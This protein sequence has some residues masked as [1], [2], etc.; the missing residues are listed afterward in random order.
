MKILLTAFEPFGGEDTNSSLDTLRALPEA[1]DVCRA[2]LPVTFSGSVPALQAA[3]RRVRPDA[4]LCLGQ[5]GGA[6]CIRVERV[7]LNLDDARMADNAGDIPRD[8]PIDQMGP[9][10]Y[11]ATL[12][13]RRMADAINAAGVRAVL[14]NSAGTFVC[15][16]VLYGLLHHLAPTC[17]GVPGGFIHL[18]YLAPKRSGIPL[19]DA[20]KAIETALDVVRTAVLP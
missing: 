11:F 12:P 17:P 20:V 3:I 16:H 6:E 2:V 5:A 9:A 8:R 18:P 10:A 7:G 14:S 15:N 13:V 4:V 1:P 19:D